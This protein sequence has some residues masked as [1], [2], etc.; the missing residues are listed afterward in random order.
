MPR[1][2]ACRSNTW[3]R[4]P[5]RGV[6]SCMTT[7]RLIRGLLTAIALLMIPAPASAGGWA[8]TSIDEIPAVVAGVPVTVGFTILQHGVTPVHVDEVALAV[9]G[10]DGRRQLFPARRDGPTGHYA[11]E[12]TLPAAGTYRWSS[13][14]GWFGTYE[15]GSLVVG[16]GEDRPAVG[17]TPQPLVLIGAGGLCAVIAAADAL[18]ALRRRRRAAAHA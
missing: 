10:A 2:E 15:L 1:R 6:G 4:P 16:S 9:V 14:Q 18:L 3:N 7:S 13:E 5:A 11:V 8:V 17:L 12:M